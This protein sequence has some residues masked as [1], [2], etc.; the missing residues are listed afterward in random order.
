MIFNSFF[1]FSEHEIKKTTK[2]SNVKIFISILFLFILNEIQI[3]KIYSKDY[4]FK[5]INS[6]DYIILSSATLLNV[7]NLL[8]ENYAKS[9]LNTILNLDKNN[10]K[11]IDKSSIYDYNN[12]YKTLSDITVLSSLALPTVYSIFSASDFN[13]FLNYNIKYAQVLGITNGLTLLSK[14]LITRYRPYTYQDNLDIDTRRSH[15]GRNSFFSGHTAMAFSSAVFLA[16][17]F[18]KSD[19]PRYAKNILWLSSIALASS[20]GYLRIIAGKHFLTDVIVGALIGS[21]V[22]ILISESYHKNFI[23]TNTSNNI[24]NVQINYL[25]FK[26]NL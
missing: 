14:N 19:N 23:V 6:Q 12:N 16:Y 13:Q 26:F 8:F 7:S 11:S 25:T 5:K 10:I 22:A 4:N 18:E 24:E 21:T 1:L 3:N 15:D 20:T 17:N 2:M 9:D